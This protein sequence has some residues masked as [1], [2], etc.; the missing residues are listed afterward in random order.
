MG[1]DLCMVDKPYD[2]PYSTTPFSKHEEK[3][4]WDKVYITRYLEALHFVDDVFSSFAGESF[5]KTS[6]CQ[7]FWHSFDFVVTR[8]SG[9]KVD[10]F[11]ESDKRTDIEAYSHEVK[12]FGFWPGDP[13]T[14]KA[15]FYSYTSPEP[16]GIANCPLNPKEAS[17]VDVGGSHLALLS[18]E[19]ILSRK[20]PKKELLEFLESAYVA[21]CN[22]KSW[23]DFEATETK[24]ILYFDIR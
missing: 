4:N 9:K 8:F 12:S 18:Y 7:L 22:S 15:M 5:Y 14:P 16:E 20:D 24:N 1:F 13:K 17:W 2:N 21:G 3:R 19:D 10:M 6:P 23:Q 11:I